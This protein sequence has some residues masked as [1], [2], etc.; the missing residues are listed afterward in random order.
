[1]RL[2]GERGREVRTGERTCAGVPVTSS[3][4]LSGAFLR[5]LPVGRRPEG[6]SP[7]RGEVTALCSDIPVSVGVCLPRVRPLTLS[8]AFCS[9]EE[10]VLD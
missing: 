4:F 7:P 3:T 8:G 1:M 6:R 5:S 10:M 9:A 2:W